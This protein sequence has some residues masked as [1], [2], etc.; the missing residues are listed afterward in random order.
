MWEKYVLC[1]ETVGRQSIYCLKQKLREF[2]LYYSATT[3]HVKE[4]QNIIFAFHVPSILRRLDW[5]G[6]ECTGS[7]HEN[8]GI[9]MEMVGMWRQN[10]DA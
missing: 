10:Q 5:K 1:T 2:K 9:V 6:S 8:L 7:S 3:H 4:V